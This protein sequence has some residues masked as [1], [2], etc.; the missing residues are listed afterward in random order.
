MRPNQQTARTLSNLFSRQSNQ[1]PS[2]QLLNAKLNLSY[3]SL[4]GCLFLLAKL[5]SQLI[6]RTNKI[7]FKMLKSYLSAR[8]KQS[9]RLPQPLQAL[10]K[11]S[12]NKLKR[13]KIKI[14]RSDSLK[15]RQ[16][17]SHLSQFT[18]TKESKKESKSRSQIHLQN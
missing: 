1:Q 7:R 6:V 4:Q 18:M 17:M 10:T 13:A 8:D 3:H 9:H 5:S 16:R 15:R 14:S 12:L 2:L 11:P